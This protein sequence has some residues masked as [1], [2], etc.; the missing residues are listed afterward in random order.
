M[1]QPRMKRDLWRGQIEILRILMEGPKTWTDLKKRTGFKPP[2]LS[3]YLKVLMTRGYAWRDPETKMYRTP[4]TQPI[5][6]PE[7]MNDFYSA[8]KELDE[9]GRMISEGGLGERVF[10][11]SEAAV[12]THVLMLAA[13]M[14]TILYASLGGKGPYEVKP[15]EAK[16][17]GFM[18]E[19]LE[20]M[21]ED[22]HTLADD[23]IDVIFRPWIHKLLDIA[24]VLDSDSKDIVCNVG[25]QLM[26]G[27]S[28]ELED[29]DKLLARC[30]AWPKKEQKKD[31]RARATK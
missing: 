21:Y 30:R 4:W 23:L 9:I 16:L 27:A 31:G 24:L 5:L 18:D 17:P 12:R 8:S 2:T 29:L 13:A 14:P 10:E 3:E 22:S 1:E 28:K 20:R 19:L 7:K 6:F 26:E 25:E 15:G 11:L